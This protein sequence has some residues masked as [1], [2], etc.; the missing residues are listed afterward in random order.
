MLISFSLFLLSLDWSLGFFLPGLWM[1]VAFCFM[2]AIAIWFYNRAPSNYGYQT[3]ALRGPRTHHEI[4]RDAKAQRE[5]ELLNV[6]IDQ[7]MVDRKW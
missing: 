6:R 7:H 4:R 5:Q 1:I 2:A 3:E